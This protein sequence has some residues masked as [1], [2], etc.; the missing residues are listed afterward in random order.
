MDRFKHDETVSVLLLPMKRGAQ[1]LNL[2]EAQHVLLLEPVL[3]PGMEAQAIK[4]V[5]RI[6]QTRPT[7]VHRFV[8]RDTVEENVQKF[9]T[10]RS[11]AMCDVSS[12]LSMHKKGKEDGL[13][14]GEI[15]ALLLRPTEFDD[16][17]TQTRAAAKGDAQDPIHVD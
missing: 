16:A 10:E 8:I 7:C 9:S 11:N 12:D 5:D 17:M 4:R 13:T 14:L 1:G 2:T 15:R 6:G 3:D